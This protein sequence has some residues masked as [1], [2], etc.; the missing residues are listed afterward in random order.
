[1]KEAVSSLSLIWIDYIS[2]LFYN[3]WILVND[4]KIS[5][6]FISALWQIFVF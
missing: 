6:E 2:I 5:R 1:M 4:L 3:L